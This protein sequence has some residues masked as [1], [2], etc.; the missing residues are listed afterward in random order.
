MHL[1]ALR[2]QRRIFAYNLTNNNFHL[3]FIADIHYIE[4]ICCHIVHWTFPWLSLYLV[5]SNFITPQIRLQLNGKHF[6]RWIFF[7]SI[8]RLLLTTAFSLNV[9]NAYN[10][11]AQCIKCVQWFRLISF[12]SIIVIESAGLITHPSTDFFEYNQQILS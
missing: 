12:I 8:I 4:L 11:F 10:D 7:V 6:S 3:I 1:F 9:S 5:F 2:T